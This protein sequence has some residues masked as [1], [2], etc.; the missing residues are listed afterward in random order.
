GSSAGGGPGLCAAI[1]VRLPRCSTG[2]RA[3]A[4]LADQPLHRRHRVESW[5]WRC[6]A[7][8]GAP[9]QLDPPCA[10]SVA[11]L[12]AALGPPAREAAGRHLREGAT[13][14]EYVDVLAE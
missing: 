1:R 8:R 11:A 14:T 12:L 9:G 6:S 5:N 4:A 10:G 2:L 7:H 3:R 13:T